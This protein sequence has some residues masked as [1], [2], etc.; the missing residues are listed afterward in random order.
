MS[1]ELKII[2]SPDSHDALVQILKSGEPCR[3]LDAPAGTGILAKQLRN[4]GYEVHCVDIDA[5]NFKLSDIPLTE[6]DLNS[7]I[8]LPDKS[9]DTV[10]CA[11]GVHRLY[12]LR[13][14]FQEFHRVLNPG[15]TL[16]VNVNNYASI[17]KRLRFLLYGSVDNA[18][19]DPHCNQTVENPQANVRVAL[20]VPHIV[21]ELRSAGFELISI[22]PAAVRKSDVILAPLGWI[23]RILSL[24]IPSRSSLRNHIKW[25]NCSGVLPGG[26]YMLLEARRSR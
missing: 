8:E 4:W 26:R 10:V 14:C 3:V 20:F 24:F 7:R 12:N 23:F 22:R 13:K 9:F 6:S 19:N 11:N 5:G 15:G 2:G 17:E 18:I 16:W 21:N 25:T 1:E